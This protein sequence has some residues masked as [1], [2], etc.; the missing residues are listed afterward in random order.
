LY[1][2]LDV[3]NFKGKSMMIKQSKARRAI[4]WAKEN[5]TSLY[6]AAK[7]FGMAA[8]SLYTEVKRAKLRYVCPCCMSSL[9]EERA[10]AARAAF[11]NRR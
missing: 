2:T 9:S 11:D 10:E 4:A 3:F 1:A 7:E 8:N 5:N 6:A